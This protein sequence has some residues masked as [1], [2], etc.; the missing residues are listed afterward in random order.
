M[1][2]RRWPQAPVLLIL[3]ALGCG[4]S[5]DL[6]RPGADP[7]QEGRCTLDADCSGGLIC[8][9]SRCVSPEDLLPPDRE[10]DR[11]AGRPVQAG[12]FL[13]TLAPDAGAVLLIDP[14]DLS[15]QSVPVASDPVALLALPGRSEAAVLSREGRRLGLLAVD[16]DLPRLVSLRL[17]R[18][19][20]GL[21]LSPDGRFAVLF[22][23][24]GA[25]PDAGAEGL[26]AVI[27]LDALARG[28]A[29]P[30]EVAA[31]YRHVGVYFRAGSHP[32]ALVVGKDEVFVIDLERTVADPVLAPTRVVLPEAY[33]DVAGREVL[34]L[35]GAGYLLLRS[36]A[37]AGVGVLEVETARF[38]VVPLPALPTD[39]ELH[40]AGDRVLAALRAAGALAILPLPAALT[41]S[42]AVELIAIPQ[43][44]PGLVEISADGRLAALYGTQD[45]SERFAL[46]DLET[47][48][49]RVIDRL[50]K[51]LRSVAFSP[52]T[53]SVVV[54]H[55]AEPDSTVA[56]PYERAVDRDE[57]YSLVDLDRGRTQL[58]R[59][60]EA[61][62]VELVF[63]PTTRRAALTLRHDPSRSF[64]V[65]ALDLETLIARSHPLGSA[66]QFAGALAAQAGHGERVWITQEHPAGRLSVLELATGA[67]RT[68]T[69]YRLNAEIER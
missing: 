49:L 23:P 21:A 30:V 29:V 39:L 67:L 9:E 34:A 46:L 38:W 50:R 16:G 43:V 56:D 22:T 26:V 14:A 64:R 8:R 66:P 41:S 45:G 61:A 59:T 48:E 51:I 42:A 1:R 54:L 3:G 10:D 35:E 55:R 65:E 28:E 31:G 20:G 40:P 69:G 17:P 7:G 13:L 5:A 15:V 12:R 37:S 53:E 44:S 33:G 60:G 19:Y 25:P 58:V 11:L 32:S 27:D 36:F 68:L 63:A 62:P 2:S 6:A 18:R 47:R 52:D 57:G 24:D 4:D